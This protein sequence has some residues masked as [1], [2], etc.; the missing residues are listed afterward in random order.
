MKRLFFALWPDEV[1]RQKIWLISEAA[2]DESLK[3]VRPDNFHVT[4]VFLG[5]TDTA[6][7]QQLC[8]AMQFIT[9]DSISIRFE[10]FTL[11][12]KGGILC[13]TSKHQPQQITDLVEKITEHVKLTSLRIDE[14]PYTAHITLARKAKRKPDVLFEPFIWQA[15]EFALVE[16][17]STPNGVNYQ[18]LKT[19]PLS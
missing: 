10:R 12:Q 7:E 2:V 1:T 6:T 15:S 16:S 5:Q 18:V 3:I 14:R 19:W 9:A 11:W 4:L 17:Q 8:D 13:L